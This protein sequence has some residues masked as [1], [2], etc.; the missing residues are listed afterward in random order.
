MRADRGAKRT[1]HGARSRTSPP[2]LSGEGDAFH[3]E[4][5][6]P[7]KSQSGKRH[8]PR[9][10]DRRTACMVILHWPRRC[11]CRA[12][13]P[14]YEVVSAKRVV[15]V[16]DPSFRAS[17]AADRRHR[18]PVV[19]RP[20]NQP[21]C[22]LDHEPVIIQRLDPHSR[23][24]GPRAAPCSRRQQGSADTAD[25]RGRGLHGSSAFTVNVRESPPTEA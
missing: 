22:L 2:G 15:A 17:E 10:L 8:D 16:P 20:S 6:L 14:I 11:P 4:S 1:R 9:A 23:V 25:M 19:G 21:R 12:V 18:P 13:Q 5:A 3:F 24:H 7:H